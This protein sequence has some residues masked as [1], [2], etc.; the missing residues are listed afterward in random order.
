MAK[1]ADFDPKSTCK[2][3]KIKFLTEKNADFD[4][5]FL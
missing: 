5:K 2:W 3:Q 1:N 4:L